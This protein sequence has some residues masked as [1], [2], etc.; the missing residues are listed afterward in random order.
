VTRA[1]ALAGLGLLAAA[2]LSG[3]SAET[4]QRLL[5]YVFDGA[6]EPGRAE[7]PPTRRVRQDLQR[8]IEA[9]RREN[10]DLRAAAQNA[11][12]RGRGD[13]PERPAERA[14]TWT[15]AMTLL[16]HDA[17]GAV[18]WNRSVEAGAIRPRPGLDPATPVQAGFD[19]DVEVTR[20]GH[21][22]FASGF[23][24]APHTRWLA[25]GSCHPSLFPLAPGAPRPAVTMAA[26]R[27]GRACGAC[28]GP[29][30]FAVETRC[31]ACHARVPATDTWQPPAPA[32]ALEGART[33]D[34]AR[35][36]LPLKGSTPDW[37][38]ARAAGLLA[39]RPRP[40]AAAVEPLDLDVTR[41][42]KEGEAF[43]A[44]FRHAVHTAWLACESCHPAP[45]QM[46]AGAT[47]MTMAEL[48]KGELC[49]R[50]HGKVAFP[51]AE[52][53]R[54]HPALGS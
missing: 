19:L 46:Q 2:L 16:A 4:R 5:P 15:E 17:D 25:C 13:A 51:M 29:V 44:V 53:A 28:H 1:P 21:P 8:E 36:G 39:P 10:A 38:A 48:D 43:K 23:R 9:L 18:D 7:P 12:E 6:P 52:C 22:F 3:C 49:G 45:F 33:W 31:P 35:A 41:V 27:A 30:A 34:E 24:H 20:G 42:P 54:C 50:C 40:G 26:I 11:A 47:P 37:E 32:R 14:R